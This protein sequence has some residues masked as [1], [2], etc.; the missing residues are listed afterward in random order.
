M[1]YQRG[2]LK[3]RRLCVVLVKAMTHERGKERRRA[4]R[5]RGII[6]SN[7][8]HDRLRGETVCRMSRVDVLAL[9][10]ESVD[11]GCVPDLE[12]GE[13]LIDSHGK[14]SFQKAF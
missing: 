11:V 2:N 6:L 8:F 7:G 3:V 10:N 13:I 9:L 4:K 5:I 1:H 14:G 12:K